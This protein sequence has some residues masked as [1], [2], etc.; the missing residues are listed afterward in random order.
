MTAE[1]P[2]SGPSPSVG[3]V[4]ASTSSNPGLGRGGGFELR[5]SRRTAEVR[6]EG[7]R[8]TRPAVAATPTLSPNTPPKAPIPRRFEEPPPAPRLGASTR[9]RPGASVES[10][11]KLGSLGTGRFD[12][13]AG[14]RL[15]R[16]CPPTVRPFRSRDS[17]YPAPSTRA[18]TFERPPFRFSRASA[19]L[20]NP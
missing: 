4:E 1:T 13:G 6:R 8:E 3:K 20:S 5:V 16:L 18:E 7:G 2:P 11:R 14:P 12:G 15:D 9:E 19:T 10:S 17:S